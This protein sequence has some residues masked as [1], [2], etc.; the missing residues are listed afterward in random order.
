MNFINERDKSDIIY[1]QKQIEN[2]DIDEIYN[3][4]KN[5][6]LYKSATT[7]YENLIN[8]ILTN[9]FF[10]NYSQNNKEMLRVAINSLISHYLS[11]LG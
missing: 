3:E 4:L 11:I 9:H 7:C 8:D 10:K 6:K 5:K 1:F 2:K